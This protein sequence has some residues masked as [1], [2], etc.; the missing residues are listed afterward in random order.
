[1]SSNTSLDENEAFEYTGNGQTVPDDVVSVRFHSSVTEIEKNEFK[2][3]WRLEKVVFNA[4]IKKIG[5][6]AFFGC[7]KL[8]VILNL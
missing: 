7:Y 3:C 5:M 6:G 2:T 4:G 8:K 1:M